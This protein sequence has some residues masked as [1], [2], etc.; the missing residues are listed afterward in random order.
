MSTTQ[1]PNAPAASHMLWFFILP[2]AVF[3]GWATF[4]LLTG[5]TQ[6]KPEITLAEK[7]RN[8]SKGRSDGDRWK[9]AYSFAEEL[10]KDLKLYTQQEVRWHIPQLLV[11]LDLNKAQK[12]KAYEIVMDWA[13]TDKSKIVGYY[14]F[15]AAADFAESDDLLLQD[16]IPRIRKANKTGAKSI[17]NRCKK[18]AKQLGIEL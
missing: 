18:I 1:K 11:H 3:L 7:A 13:E 10:L 16:F 14:G 6:K 9:S 15:Q 4:Q 5:L 2:V 17:Q 8:I 12:R